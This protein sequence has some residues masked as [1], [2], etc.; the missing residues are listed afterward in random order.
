[1]GSKR[2]GLARFEALM[3]NLKREIDFGGGSSAFKNIKS[4]A[5]VTVR[6]ATTAHDLTATSGDLTVI[7]TGTMDG[8]ITLPQATAGNV[9]MVIKI[10]YAASA[11]NTAR[12]LG[13]TNAGS[14]VITGNLTVGALDAAAGDENISF[15]ITSNSKVFAIDANDATSG[16]GAAGSTYT[17]TYFGANTVFCEAHALITTGTPAPDAASTSATGIS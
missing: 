1:M 4:N 9:G 5:N 15:A 16:G 6:S 3:E 17:F 7:Y 11:S 8:N 14:T 10:I 12:K 13:F 2:I